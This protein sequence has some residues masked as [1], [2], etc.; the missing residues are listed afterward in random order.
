[1]LIK[2]IVSKYKYGLCEAIKPMPN[3]EWS[4]DWCVENWGTKWGAYENYIDEELDSN[5][6]ITHLMYNFQTAWSSFYTEIEQGIVELLQNFIWEWE[7]EQGFGQYMEVV[8]GVITVFRD[9]D[10]PEWQETE[11]DSIFR[12]MHDYNGIEDKNAGWYYDTDV[13]LTDV[14]FEEAVR[15]Y[16]KELRHVSY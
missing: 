15:I 3:N 14:S 6:E 1:M 7:E 8:D 5:N 16:E 2:A 13:Y 9:W 12:L 11:H 10:I 4:Y